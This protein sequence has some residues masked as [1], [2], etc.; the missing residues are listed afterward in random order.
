MRSQG[1]FLTERVSWSCNVND[2]CKCL[3]E[4]ETYVRFSTGE[5]LYD[6]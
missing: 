4:K 2:I 3:I 1:R 6:H 5:K